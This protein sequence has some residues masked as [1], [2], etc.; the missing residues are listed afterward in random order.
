MNALE[1]KSFFLLLLSLLALLTFFVF[2][3][4]IAFLLYNKKF[5]QLIIL[6]I[7]SLRINYF[8][9]SQNDVFSEIIH[10]DGR[11]DT[12]HLG[13]EQSLFSGLYKVKTQLSIIKKYFGLFSGKKMGHYNSR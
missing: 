8:L 10:V 2:F 5:H 7:R 11:I 12:E 1:E 6:F 3:F 9:T 13:G 4:E